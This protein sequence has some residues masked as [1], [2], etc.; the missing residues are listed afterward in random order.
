MTL[1]IRYY[2]GRLCFWLLGRCPGC[3]SKVNYTVAGS[4]ICPGCGRRSTF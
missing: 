3:W 4:A 1:P 2:W